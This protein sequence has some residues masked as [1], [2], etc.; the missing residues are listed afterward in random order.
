[1]EWIFIILSAIGGLLGGAFIGFLIYI[2]YDRI[3]IASLARR[4]PHRDDMNAPNIQEISEKEV[5][6]NERNRFAK[7]REFEKLRRIIPGGKATSGPNKEIRDLRSD[8][9]RS[10]LQGNTISNLERERNDTDRLNQGTQGDNKE[11]RL[12]SPDDF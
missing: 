11:A 10:E 5:E 4:I 3:K 9:R 6:E 7:F 1:M 2:I 12:S 8:V